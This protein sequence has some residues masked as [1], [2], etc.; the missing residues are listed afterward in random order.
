M[1]FRRLGSRVSRRKGSARRALL[2]YRIAQSASDDELVV[3]DR[4]MDYHVPRPM[5]PNPHNIPLAPPAP[6]P[7][8][9][10]SIEIGKRKYLQPELRVGLEETNDLL[11]RIPA[12]LRARPSSPLPSQRS[13]KSSIPVPQRKL[14]VTTN[15]TSTDITT[16]TTINHNNNISKPNRITSPRGI[17]QNSPPP[18]SSHMSRS[19]TDT[20][21]SS[22]TRSPPTG[23]LSDLEDDDDDDTTNETRTGCSRWSNASTG[24]SSGS[25]SLYSTF[26]TDSLPASEHDDPE[27]LEL[28]QIVSNN[29]Q[30]RM[31]ARIVP[32]EQQQ[33]RR[34]SKESFNTVPEDDDSDSSDDD[35]LFVDATGVS[36]E[37]IEREKMER[38]LSKR[39]SGG[40]FGSAGGLVLAIGK[41]A[42]PPPPPPPPVPALPL[43]S[44]QKPEEKEE[45]GNIKVEI[46]QPSLSPPPRPSPRQKRSV[47]LE[48]KET[49]T[50]KVSSPPEIRLLPD[51]Q[52]E[53]KEAAKKLWNEDEAFV[54]KERIAEWLG[55]R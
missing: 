28:S 37:D 36:Q 12:E 16:T 25:Y 27:Q 3:E 2:T 45:K 23:T 34:P 32:A 46:V 8:K 20:C 21:I 18:P 42:T 11:S 7:P 13:P 29:V 9:I 10:P 40:H 24:K 54:P 52:L 6:P 38:R 26:G 4:K 15:N 22:Y 48:T 35:D 44:P 14:H 39:L 33:E 49:A 43:S 50:L 31:P 47:P 51:E 17:L 55:Q 41:T 5:T 19:F 30:R 53:A 1:L